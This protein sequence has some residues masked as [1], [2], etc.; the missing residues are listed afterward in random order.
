[1]AGGGHQA[2]IRRQEYRETSLPAF[3]R[4]GGGEKKTVEGTYIYID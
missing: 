4:M 3:R 1:M 2:S